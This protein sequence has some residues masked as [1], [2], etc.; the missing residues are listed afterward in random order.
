MKNAYPTEDGAK[1]HADSL[2]EA[3]PDPLT[4][5]RAYSCFWTDNF[6]AGQIAPMHWHVGR[7]KK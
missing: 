3:Y 1:H 6:D 7:V 5:Y 4:V 2:N